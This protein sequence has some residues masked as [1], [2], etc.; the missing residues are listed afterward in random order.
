M[1]TDTLIGT[2]RSKLVDYANSKGLD[3]G[4]NIECVYKSRHKKG[5]D[6]K[7][8]M[9]LLPSKDALHCFTCGSVIDIFQLANSLDGLPIG[10]NPDFYK[11]TLPYLAKEILGIEYNA[12]KLDEESKNIFLIKRAYSFAITYAKYNISCAKEYIEKRG[13]NE[14]IS[15]RFQLG[16]IES[17][18]KFIS[19]MNKAGFNNDFLMRAGILNEKLFNENRLI[20]PIFDDNG[21][22]IRIVGRSMTNDK[23]KYINTPNNELNSGIMKL[24]GLP[25][26]YASEFVYIVEGQTDLITMY[27]YGYDN[28]FAVMGCDFNQE[29]VK[30]LKRHGVRSISILFDGDMIWANKLKTSLVKILKS[31]PINISII[32]LPDKLD[33]DE[34][35]QKYTS[36][37]GLLMFSPF[38]WLM[39]DNKN[40]ELPEHKYDQMITLISIT[41]SGIIREKMV[42]ELASI[43]KYEIA[44]IRAD[45]NE[46]RVFNQN[47]EFKR[48]HGIKNELISLARK[49]DTNL[50][51]L[52]FAIQ[53]RKKVV[54]INKDD[55]FTTAISLLNEA[56]DAADIA[57]IESS[58]CFGRLKSFERE[59]YGL[60]RHGNLI[61]V[62]GA[63]SGGK[64]SFLRF[65]VSEIA[66]T[67]DNITCVYFSIEDNK[68]KT[69]SGILSAY[70]QYEINFNANKSRMLSNHGEKATI[71]YE[72]TWN[73]AKQFVREKRLLVFDGSIG[74]SIEDI[75][76]I[77]VS[78]REDGIKDMVVVV[79]SINSLSGV[80]N[81]EN[82]AIIEKTRELRRILTKLDVLMFAVAELKKTVGQIGPQDIS[83]SR[84]VEYAADAIIMVYP[85]VNNNTQV[86][87]PLTLNSI[88]EAVPVI[89]LHIQKNKINGWMGIIP[90]AFAKTK[91]IFVE[92]NRDGGCEPVST[93][94]ELQDIKDIEE[95][96]TI[97]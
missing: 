20:I 52:E 96:K 13:W 66:R 90:L 12:E 65:L 26:S 19:H 76:H 61:I 69:I 44:S 80:E 94:T 63:P 17:F 53:R 48:L 54:N 7:P 1:N 45:V 25:S 60:S 23:P 95:T 6:E 28:C 34:Y 50:E 59:T 56:K 85:R 27:K 5:T 3:L 58:I 47:N 84:R 46:K 77:L 22:V 35:L 16:G 30:E 40:K 86:Q 37:N 49:D 29:H 32:L 82:E 67:N 71:M 97:V 70:N 9:G 89:N 93:L 91:N 43:T 38:E 31:E 75:E 78:L 18:N 83:Y 4:T 24:Y 79:D 11:I 8:S 87:V 74:N 64:S 14:D 88:S 55:V 42:K 10:S 33:P 2:L 81:G 21:N 41:P 39:N 36:L 68:E 72:K 62:S 51:D 73:L 15:R 92:L 57:S